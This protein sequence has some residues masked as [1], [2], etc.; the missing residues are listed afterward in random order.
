MSAA[1]LNDPAVML[2][3]EEGV[4]DGIGLENIMGEERMDGWTR[5]HF[6]YCVLISC[7]VL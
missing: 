5:I 6:L 3:M 7:T 4:M 2:P 1:L